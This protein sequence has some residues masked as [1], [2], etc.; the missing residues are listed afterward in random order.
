MDDADRF[1]GVVDV[2]QGLPV[3][4]EEPVRRASRSGS[5]FSVVLNT[6]EVDREKNERGVEILIGKTE[7]ADQRTR[8]QERDDLVKHL[9]VRRKD[10]EPAVDEAMWAGCARCDLVRRVGERLGVSLSGVGAIGWGP[11][12]GGG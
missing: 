9:P 8:P 1:E 10:D 4:L 7:R 12:G 5:G 6:G 2:R 11:T 3:I